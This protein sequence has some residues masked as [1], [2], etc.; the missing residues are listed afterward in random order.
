MYTSRKSWSTNYTYCVS[1]L[2]WQVVWSGFGWVTGWC[3]VTVGSPWP[4]GEANQVVMSTHCVASEERCVCFSSSPMA[5]SIS[6]IGVAWIKTLFA[7]SEQSCSSVAEIRKWMSDIPAVNEGR[8][9]SHFD[10]TSDLTNSLKSRSTADL[11]IRKKRMC[12]TLKW[13]GPPDTLWL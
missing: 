7:Y 5:C 8:F 4:D 6:A 11:P 9:T 1:V 12:S 10:P 3:V 2:D 13:P